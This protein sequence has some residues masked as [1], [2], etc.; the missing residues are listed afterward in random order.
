MKK[1]L[2][3]ICLLFLTGCEFNYN[4]IIDND[5]IKETGAVYFSNEELDGLSIQEKLKKITNKYFINEDILIGQKEE[6]L[7]IDNQLG[8]RVINN[9]DLNENP[10]ITTVLY[11]YENVNI[12]NNEKIISMETTDSF[13]CYNYYSELDKFTVHIYSKLKNL[14][15]NADLV[16][17]NDYYWY[18]TKDN[19]DNKKIEFE[20]EKS[21]S[22]DEYILL[23][24]FG[25]ILICGLVVTLILKSK[26]NKNNKF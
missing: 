7:D 25:I 9:Y 1:I 12:I 3:L 5:N 18:I 19:Y 11:C 17:G 21:K 10:E 24:I 14:K 15:N 20:F 2:I 4:L 23:C 16:N 13:L 6:Y 8:Y 26:N 22:N